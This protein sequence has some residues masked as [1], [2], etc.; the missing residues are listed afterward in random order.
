MTAVRCRGER[1]GENLADGGE[2]EEASQRQQ[3]PEKC[4]SWTSLSK[5]CK[6]QKS[7]TVGTSLIKG[8][9]DQK[10]VSVGSGLSKGCRNQNSVSV[11][12]GLSKGCET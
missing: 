5:G 9:R 11:G 7:V 8:C 4:L 3:R 12:T 2:A 10:I 1:C 6:D